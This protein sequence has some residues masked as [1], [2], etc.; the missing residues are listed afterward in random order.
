MILK[1]VKQDSIS[2][3]IFE[4]LFVVQSYVFDLVKGQKMIH[5]SKY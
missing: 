2:M 1:V 3:K 5:L 4:N